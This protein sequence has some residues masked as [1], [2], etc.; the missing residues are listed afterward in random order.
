MEINKLDGSLRGEIRVPGDKSISHRSVILGSISEGK[1]KVKNFLMGEDCLDT[2]KCFRKLGVKIAVNE[3]EVVIDGVGIN[4]L[5]KPEGPLYA[6]N[7]GTTI[8]LLTGLLSGQSLL[9]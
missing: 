1:T 5:K 7:S 2:I 3:R 4:G 8:R 9:F 6:G